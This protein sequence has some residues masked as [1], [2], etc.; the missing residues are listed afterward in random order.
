M[1][2]VSTPR[3][4]HLLCADE[5]LSEGY[6]YRGTYIAVGGEPIAASSRWIT[7]CPDECD[8]EVTYCPGC[9]DAVKKRNGDASLDVDCPPGTRR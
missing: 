6:R 8:C 4:P 5:V 2:G 9:L 3:C 1:A 7:S